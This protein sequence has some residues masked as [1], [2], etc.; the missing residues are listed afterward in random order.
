MSL[1]R[2]GQQQIVRPADQS[3][4][5]LRLLEPFGSDRPA[6]ARLDRLT[7]HVRTGQR[8]TGTTLGDATLAGTGIQQVS[9]S[10]SRK[11]RSIQR[12]AACA[13]AAPSSAT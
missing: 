7:H 8:S 12:G 13:G 3:S 4:S 6:G 9:P 10:I 11:P 2:V 5:V 1:F